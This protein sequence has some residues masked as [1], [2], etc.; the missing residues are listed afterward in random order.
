MLHCTNLCYI[1]K[2]NFKNIVLIQKWRNG[3]WTAIGVKE[4]ENK[5]AQNVGALVMMP[6]ERLATIAWETGMY[7]AAIAVAA[8]IRSKNI[9][10]AT[11]VI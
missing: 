1:I 9:F 4:T 3:E 8:G 11:T 10:F 6:T 2:T 5:I 7:A